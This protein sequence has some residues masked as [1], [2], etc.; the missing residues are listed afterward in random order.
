M[1]AHQEHRGA[2]GDPPEDEALGVH[3]MPLAHDVALGRK[4]GIHI[5]RRSPYET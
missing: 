2:T 1:L 4:L 5:D 3:H